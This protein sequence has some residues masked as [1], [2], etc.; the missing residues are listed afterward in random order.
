MAGQTN[1]T[2]E[3]STWA[4]KPKT[5]KPPAEVFKEFEVCY[6]AWSRN[7][8]GRSIYQAQDEERR[9]VYILAGTQLQAL[10]AWAEHF[11][12][13]VLKLKRGTMHRLLAERLQKI[14]Q[15]G[16]FDDAPVSDVEVSE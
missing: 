12:N 13:P 14:N 16:L 10:K 7:G 15:L 4:S 2:T 5:Y 11:A 6:L 9:D 8:Q 3:V 1:Q